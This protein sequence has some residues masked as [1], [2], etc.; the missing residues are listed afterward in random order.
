MVQLCDTVFVGLIPLCMDLFISLYDY[1][2][3]GAL[4][5][6]LVIGAIFLVHGVQKIKMW[7][8]QASE[9]MPIGLLWTMRLLSI[10]EPLGGIAMA[11]GVL[12]PFAALG[13]A[14]IMLG[15]ISMKQKWQT[16]FAAHDKTGWEFD[17]MILAVVVAL[18]FF[19]PGE[20]SID[21]Y[22]WGL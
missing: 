22:W 9:Q 16:P 14:V 11:L 19:G 15:A 4:L 6:R 17:L 2:D 3:V 20:Y 5:L 8:M 7:R 1:A 12:T 18:L 21:R 13:F 10:V